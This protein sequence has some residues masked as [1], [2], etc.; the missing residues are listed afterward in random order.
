MG[1]ESLFSGNALQAVDGKG[2]MVLP[3]F[4][5]RTLSR[6]TQARRLLFSPHESDPC[7]TGY[8]EPFTHWLFAEAER[9]RLRDETLGLTSA[10]HHGRVRRL[11]GAAAPAEVDARGRV[12]LPAMM[13]ARAG[14]GAAALVIG[15]GGSFEIWD[16]E[17]ARE[18]GD[19]ELAQL[20]DFVLS[21]RSQPEATEEYV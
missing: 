12:L 8:D 19:L 17:T 1:L 14:I 21:G 10:Q 7:M 15:T 11:F 18:A 3:P 2:V 4:V 6:R 13:R 20:A 16:P 9:R 5:L